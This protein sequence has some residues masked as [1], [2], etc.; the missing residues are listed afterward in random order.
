MF[1]KLFWSNQNPDPKTHKKADLKAFRPDRKGRVDMSGYDYLAQP[2]FVNFDYGWWDDASD[3]FWHANHLEYG[4]R[5][6][7][8]IVL[9]S[10]RDK[11][12]KKMEVAGSRRYGYA[13]FDRVVYGVALAKHY[14]PRRAAGSSKP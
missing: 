4:N 13:D 8:M 1:A 6:D 3:S 12:A 10:T 11:F 7:P 14:D 9:Q 2:G 5:K